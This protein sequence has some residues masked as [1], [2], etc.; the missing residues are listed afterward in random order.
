M[1]ALKGLSG[2]PILNGDP[3]SLVSNR[4]HDQTVP[5]RYAYG[6]L[7]HTLASR[8]GSETKPGVTFPRHPNALPTS[9]ENNLR[10]CPPNLA[11]DAI[12]SPSGHL[13][14][15]QS[16]S[17]V[18]ARPVSKGNSKPQSLAE[19]VPTEMQYAG[20]GLTPTT[21]VF[22]T[23]PFQSPLS[24]DFS[25]S[26]AVISQSAPIEP[27]VG[28][29]RK[30]KKQQKMSKEQSDTEKEE[31]KRKLALEQEKERQWKLLQQQRLKEQQSHQ[32]TST[33]QQVMMMKEQ[34]RKDNNKVGRKPQSV[35]ASEQDYAMNEF[36]PTVLPPVKPLTV[37][38]SSKQRPAD[39]ATTVT[40]PTSVSSHTEYP[41]DHSSTQ[42]HSFMSNE[43][44][45]RDSSGQTYAFDLRNEQSAE[46]DSLME[47]NTTDLMRIGNSRSIRG[48]SVSNTA[49]GM[50]PAYDSVASTQAASD[51]SGKGPLLPGV[52]RA[53]GD[54]ISDKRDVTS[55]SNLIQQQ[56]QHQRISIPISDPAT[57]SSSQ[58]GMFSSTTNQPENKSQ[59]SNDNHISK[60]MSGFLLDTSSSIAQTATNE[61]F[62][63]QQAA[64]LRPQQQQQ[65]QQQQALLFQ[66]QQFI[67]AQQQYIQ[68]QLQQRN[69]ELF[70]SVATPVQYSSYTDKDLPEV[71]SEEQHQER[72]RFLYRQRQMQ[73]QQ[74]VQ[75][76]QQL[77][78][79]Q[80]FTQQQVAPTSSGS[81]VRPQVDQTQQQFVQQLMQY[82]QQIPEAL[83]QQFLLEY[84]RQMQQKTDIGQN[85]MQYDKFLAELAQ[86][87]GY[88]VQQPGA[89]TVSVVQHSISWPNAT[90]ATL[91][92]N[93][94]QVFAYGAIDEE[95]AKDL[96]PQQL[97]QLQMQQTLLMQMAAS[98]MYT[99]QPA[100]IRS[101]PGS[102]A[103]TRKSTA[104]SSQTKKSRDTK[105]QDA[106]EKQVKIDSTVVQLAKVGSKASQSS[107]DGE[108]MPEEIGVS[109]HES[110]SME[111]RKADPSGNDVSTHSEPLSDVPMEKDTTAK[112]LINEAVSNSSIK[113][114]ASSSPSSTNN[115]VMTNS[116]DSSRLAN[117][118]ETAS[119][120]D[121]LH[122]MAGVSS[123]SMPSER[124]A[125]C[126]DGI[127]CGTD[128]ESEGAPDNK[129]GPLTSLQNEKAG[130]DSFNKISTT[131][132]V[133]EDGIHCGTDSEDESY[134]PE[135]RKNIKGPCADGIHCGTDSEDEELTRKTVNRKKKSCDDGIHC[136][137]DSEEEEPG[138]KQSSKDKQQCKDGIHCGTDSEDDELGMKR[139]GKSKHRCTDGIHCG[140]DSED[141]A[142]NTKK[143]ARPKQQCSDGI[144]CG[145]D[146]EDEATNKTQAGKSKEGCTDG[147]HCGTDSEDENDSKGKKILVSRQEMGTEGKVKQSRPVN[148]CS[149]GIHCGT[150]S[151]GEEDVSDKKN[152]K[153]LFESGK[154]SLVKNTGGIGSQG[155]D[156]VG[157]NLMQKSRPLVVVCRQETSISSVYSQDSTVLSFAKAKTSAAVVSTVMS[158]HTVEVIQEGD[159]TQSTFSALE[160]MSRNL[161]GTKVDSSLQE[162]FNVSALNVSSESVPLV[163]RESP[164]SKLKSPTATSLS[165]ESAGPTVAIAKHSAIHKPMPQNNVSS[166]LT[167]S[168]SGKAYSAA[169]S[170]VEALST[171][172]KSLAQSTPEQRP[173]PAISQTVPFGSPKDLNSKDTLQVVL[174]QP[175]QLQ[176]FS[177]NVAPQTPNPEQ[178]TPHRQKQKLPVIPPTSPQYQQLFM[179]QH[180][181]L[182]MQFQQYQFQLQAQYQQLSQHQMSPQQQFLLQQQ[183]HQQMMLLQ[184]QFVQQQVRFTVNHLI[185][186]RIMFLSSLFL[187]HYCSLL[188]FRQ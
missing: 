35:F 160:N 178:S 21:P 6:D 94:Q 152:S 120:V 108:K 9:S 164:V 8:P 92:P 82:Q 179:H 127:H 175:S 69:P 19:I 85:A 111:S 51:S 171:A 118:E 150:D 154:V 167:T 170:S 186:L 188:R 161:K 7:P 45:G 12:T 134:L 86:Q 1:A 132:K 114:T 93:M 119:T 184:R 112:P 172:A 104:A 62:D 5:S 89:Q 28:E 122:K 135:M 32:Q 105:K 53:G 46:L 183:Y 25:G 68:W 24:G 147:I 169:S 31:K 156:E 38:Q 27:T 129:K 77:H 110:A 128:S 91:H 74:V 153:S 22:A 138:K 117:K 130:Y 60:T 144:H 141:E 23:S 163:S 37:S 50:P 176:P 113:S 116:Q 52:S 42:Q 109:K 145:T 131:K 75:L 159:V 15:S 101:Q 168:D 73:K 139:G 185:S 2:N 102:T 124:N 16:P 103:T 55:S 4:Q 142:T 76:Q 83:Q 13:V 84:S 143:P 151:E 72:I 10:S 67:A 87:Y 174:Q 30:L 33:I 136:G 140:T 3:S 36:R 166:P 58:P 121:T 123:G 57:P 107:H 180:Q 97:Y 63:K 173:F 88:P 133:C 61:A 95:K 41:I 80:V 146:S 162:S 100:A 64:A 96:T 49:T 187:Q 47:I 157:K 14:P 177:P 44:V 158:N 149:D 148:S 165:K 81:A 56:Q 137:T 18:L 115:L 43:L 29:K 17:S 181:L 125:V 20:S 40:T 54:F 26:P 79:Q 182:I 71:D 39:V 106:H 66:Q 99:G 11:T 78:Q 70:Q 155:S 90:A 126:S 34:M 59:R 98:G 65:Q 48:D